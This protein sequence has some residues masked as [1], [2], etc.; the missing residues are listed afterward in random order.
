MFRRISLEDIEEVF[1]P[2]APVLRP[3]MFVGRTQELDDLRTAIRQR[4]YHPIVTGDRGVGKTSLARQAFAKSGVRAVFV[5]CD[6]ELTFDGIARN[7]LRELGVDVSVDE[8][9]SESEAGIS[10]GGKVFGIGAEASGKTKRS[11]KRRELGSERLDPWRFYVALREI[12]HKI[13]VVLDEYDVM[14]GNTAFNRSVAT[15]IKTLSDHSHECDAR[16]V[17]VGIGRSAQ[18]LLGR[19][20]SI[21]R[22]ATEIH[23]NPLSPNAVDAFLSSAENELNIRFATTVKDS[24]VD[25]SSGYPYFVHLVGRECLAAM[26]RR[27]PSD[28]Y[29][30]EHDYKVAIDQAV[31][32]AFRSELRKYS[33]AMRSLDDLAMSMIREIAS[34]GRRDRR[35]T[36][37][38]LQ[39]RVTFVMKVSSSDVQ[40]AFERL[41]ESGLVYA[42]STNNY[43]RFRDPLLGP[44]IRAWMLPELGGDVDV[45]Q[46]QLFGESGTA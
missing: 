1:T 21:E 8:T 24:I 23:L 22:S 43:I 42:T 12:G 26:Y 20:E 14:A 34:L 36:E 6:P 45:R 16:L 33:G 29:V 32:K 18:V 15:L 11:E 37:A 27:D 13:V 35:V 10:G 4:G 5:E 31:R 19:H 30:N 28:N 17:V 2:G 7:A 9:Q 25:T 46:L 38:E 41:H 44:F 3:E 40:A 39:K